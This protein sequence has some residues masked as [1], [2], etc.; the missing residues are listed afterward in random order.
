MDITQRISTEEIEFFTKK[1]AEKINAEGWEGRS[2]E[3]KTENF[4]NCWVTEEAFKKLLMKN[5]AFF[6][7][8]GL[9]VGDAAGAG[10]DFEVKENDRWI[11]I[12][13][14]S[15]N[16]DSLNRW[17]S[18]AYPEDRFLTEQHKIP[19]YVVACHNDNGCV[20]FLGIIEK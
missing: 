9:Y 18:V 2:T 16:D 8:R 13:V 19:D 6:R 4:V 7:H 3:Q 5:K 1:A 15:I 14:R 11:T 20:T 12:G 10:V 17:K